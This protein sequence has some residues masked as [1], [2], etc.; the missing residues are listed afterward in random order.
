[1]TLTHRYDIWRAICA[2]IYYKFKDVCAKAKVED[3]PR[4]PVI[5]RR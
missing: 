3:Y 5:R 2:A 4:K 1:M